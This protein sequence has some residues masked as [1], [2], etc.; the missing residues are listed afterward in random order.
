VFGTSNGRRQG[1]T[2]VRKRVLAP[3]VELANRRLLA[4]GSS[5]LPE[6][7]TPHSLRRTFASLLYAI[8]ED[9]PTVMAEMGHTT[10]ALALRIYA[11]AMRRDEGEKAR[12]R[13]L[14]EGGQLADIGSRNLEASEPAGGREAI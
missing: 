11:Q 5:P 6:R 13:A 9:P 1:A 8:G 4:A 10:P 3:A 2:N 14:V 12:L 7:L